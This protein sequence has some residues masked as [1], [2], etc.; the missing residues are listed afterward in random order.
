[1]KSE[2]FIYELW[3]LVSQNCLLIVWT[4][5]SLKR[6]RLLLITSKKKQRC[7]RFLICLSIGNGVWIGITRWFGGLLRK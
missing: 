1:M 3:L 2:L 5:L 4:D 7:R 6:F